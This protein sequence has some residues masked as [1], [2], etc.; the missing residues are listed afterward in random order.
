MPG[1]PLT[2]SSKY[3]KAFCLGKSVQAGQQQ[4]NPKEQLE[5]HGSVSIRD[6]SPV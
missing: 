3:P 1:A 6:P 4:V 5:K 2:G